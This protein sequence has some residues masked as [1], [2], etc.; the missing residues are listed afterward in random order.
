MR[1]ALNNGADDV[2]FSVGTKAEITL[3]CTL[4]YIRMYSIRA[5]KIYYTNMKLCIT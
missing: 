4:F 3:D 2:E 5:W 1:R